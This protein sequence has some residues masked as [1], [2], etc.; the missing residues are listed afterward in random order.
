MESVANEGTTAK[1]PVNAFLIFCKQHRN[2]VRQSNP[3]MDNRAVTKLLGEIWAK[4]RPDEKNEYLDKAQK[5]KEGFTNKNTEYKWHSYQHKLAR[6][7]S[8]NHEG[9]FTQ[10]QLYFGFPAGQPQV[11]CNFLGDKEHLIMPKLRNWKKKAASRRAALIRW[12]KINPSSTIQPQ[13]NDSPQKMAPKTVQGRM[14]G[15][16]MLLLAGQQQLYNDEAKIKAVHPPRPVQ[17]P[18][19]N[20]SLYERQNNIPKLATPA[21]TSFS[22]HSSENTNARTFSQRQSH[23]TVLNRSLNFVQHPSQP[24]QLPPCVYPNENVHNSTH[25][26]RTYDQNIPIDYSSS[27]DMP[28]DLSCK[29]GK[30]EKQKKMSLMQLA[31]MCSSQLQAVESQK[32]PQNQSTPKRQPSPAKPLNTALNGSYQSLSAFISHK[33]ETTVRG[34]DTQIPTV[35]TTVNKKDENWNER[36]NEPKQEQL[37][38]KMMMDRIIENL[39]S[40]NTSNNSKSGVSRSA[41]FQNAMVKAE[42]QPSENN[43]YQPVNTNTSSKMKMK[44]NA[45]SNANT[46]TNSNISVNPNANSRN[47]APPKKRYQA[48]AA[49]TKEKTFVNYGDVQESLIRSIIYSDSQMVKDEKEEKKIAVVP[50]HTAT[51][52]KQSNHSHQSNHLKELSKTPVSLTTIGKGLLNTPTITAMAAVIPHVMWNHNHIDTPNDVP[53]EGSHQPLPSQKRTATDEEHIPPKKRREHRM[54]HTPQEQKKEETKEPRP[55]NKV[56]EKVQQNNVVVSSSESTTSANSLPASPA[57]SLTGSQKRKAR[58]KGI[59]RL[60]VNKPD[61]SNAEPGSPTTSEGSQLSQSVSDSEM[62]SNEQSAERNKKSETEVG[63]EKR[64]NSH[65]ANDNEEEEDEGRLVIDE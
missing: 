44:T 54:V 33:I 9:N 17:V 21:L 28:L 14:G 26:T 60:I 46:H 11:F 20:L 38:G 56:N 3:T 4:M 31:E 50:P 57:N 16:D 49:N 37:N 55:C 51:A 34:G 13:L 64:N 59:T 27:N 62:S 65:S 19:Q 36:K 52:V 42:G 43:V 63:T 23:A 24:H 32:P 53:K 30:D 5:Q 35:N 10:S 22:P 41:M 58:R 8:S 47:S 29:K 6:E 39:L 7:N 12:G 61:T 15:L 1:R 25:L 48:Q 40:Q 45:N 2:R 18:Q